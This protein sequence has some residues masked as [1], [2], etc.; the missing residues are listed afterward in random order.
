M[1]SDDSHRALPA[2]GAP[3]AD[4]P[5]ATT[6]GAPAGAPA[7]TA[8]RTARPAA[9]DVPD[10]D[11]LAAIATPAAVRRAP[12]IGAFIRTGVLLGALVGWLLAI[13]FSGTTGEARTGA[14]LISTVAVACLGALLG[15]AAAALADRRSTRTA[16]RRTAA[17]RT[18]DR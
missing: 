4:I 14:I 16:S 1:T 5:A 15:A 13:I 10:E 17:R 8:P 2:A 6:G 9:D 7:P 18:G 11:T 12:R 3:E